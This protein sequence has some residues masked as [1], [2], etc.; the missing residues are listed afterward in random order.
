M[1][2]RQ[3]PA[4][5]WT[6]EKCHQESKKYNT[7]N[8]FQEK[9]RGA[10]NKALKSGWLNEIGSHMTVVKKPND[11]W[12][13]ERCH[14][15]ALKFETRSE[16]NKK[17]GS[18]S[19]K[20]KKNGWYKEICSHMIR[21]G[22]RRHKLIYSYEFPDRAVYVGL[23]YNIQDRKT[24]RKADLDDA[25]TKHITQTELNPSIRLLTDYISVDNAVKQEARYIKLYQ[26]NGWSVLNKSK[27]GSVGGNVIKWTKDELRKE[28]LKYKSRVEFQKSNGTAYTAVRKNG[29]LKE[30]CFHMPLLQIPNGS[31]T[32]EVCRKEARKYQTRTQFARNSAGAYDK[33]RKSGW[34]DDIC[35]H[36]TSIL[37][38]KG[39]W[40]K[41]KCKTEA[42]KYK[43][44]TEF[45]KNSPRAYDISHQNGWLNEFCS[46]MKLQKLP[47]GYWRDDKEAC[48]KESLKYKNRSEFSLRKNAAYVSAKENGWLNE[49]YPS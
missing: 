26:E 36:M 27:A 2:P 25:V 6:K 42:W 40:T 17:S 43:T 44:R 33:S 11:Y 13:K 41:E 20:A 8:E 1:I 48:R 14:S 47:N 24:R 38:P 5:Y 18:A 15:E 21:L 46:H 10:Y 28:A 39:Y 19:N 31:L 16:F 22:D 29:W 12:T 49:F 23:T 45:Q 9:S 7:R 32:K 35:S 3:K 30:L 37:K 4:N 34:L